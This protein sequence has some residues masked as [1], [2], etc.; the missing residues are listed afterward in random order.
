MSPCAFSNYY[1][2][3][4]SRLKRYNVLALCAQVLGPAFYQYPQIGPS[5]VTNLFQDAGSLTNQFWKSLINGILQPLLLNCPRE[6]FSVV[7][8]PF[9]SPFFSFIT[10]RLEAEWKTVVIR[11]EE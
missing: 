8:S 5:I 2:Q 11:D 4:S 7:L 10:Q 1:I 6:S 3:C 9:I